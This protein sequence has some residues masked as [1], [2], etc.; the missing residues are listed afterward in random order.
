MKFQFD[1]RL[2]DNGKTRKKP[3]SDWSVPGFEPG[4]P[5]ATPRSHFA[6]QVFN[7]RSLKPEYSE[8]FTFSFN[9]RAQW[10]KSGQR[11]NRVN[12]KILPPR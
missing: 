1:I 8:S 4:T 3:W 11:I 6:R 9:N 7:P 5:S 12:F 10:S 2:G